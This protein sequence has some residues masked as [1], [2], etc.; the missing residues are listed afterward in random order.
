M[1]ADSITE[2]LF[3][4]FKNYGPW[5][6]RLRIAVECGDE[7]Y[8]REIL[9]KDISDEDLV[10]GVNLFRRYKIDFMTYNML[11]LPGETLDQALL[12]L[13]LNVRLKP[14]LAICFIYQPFPGT[15]L[16]RYA[17]S[18]GFL[19]YPMLEKLGTLEYGGFFH[20]RSVLRQRE[21]EEVE[22]LHKIF[23]FVAKHPFL[24][25]FSKSIVRSRRLSFFLS[26]FYRLY[27]LKIIFLRK[28]KDGY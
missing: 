12:T 11:C 10:R 13:Q 26:W 28:L 4:A 6:L 9:G 19:S 20:S 27:T 7:T 5:L 23:S 21:I 18:K 24:F 2:G 14:S 3:E 25:P 17:L 16:S 1:R 22:N 15:E 8:R